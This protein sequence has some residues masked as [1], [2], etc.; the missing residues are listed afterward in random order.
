MAVLDPKYSIGIAEMDIQHARWVELIEQFRSVGSA[1]MLEQAGLDAAAHALEELLI[2]TRNHFSSEEHFL[3]THHYPDLDA[4]KQ[5][6]RKLEGIVAKLLEEIRAHA[7]NSSPLKLNLFI[8]IWLL[9]HIMQEDD[10]YA[11]FILGKS[12]P[13]PSSLQN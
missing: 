6:H 1:H 11:R 12:A 4:H 3:A 2:Y 8:T 10:K 5:Q 7:T 9:E 13:A